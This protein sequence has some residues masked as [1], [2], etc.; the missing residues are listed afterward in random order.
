LAIDNEWVTPAMRI[1]VGSLAGMLLV[2]AGP[3]FRRRGYALYGQILAGGGVAMLYLC[4][5]AAFNYYAL[6]GANAAFALMVLITGGAAAMAD[7]EQSQGLA[8]MAVG[9]GFFTPF[10]VNSGRDAQ[11][12]L[13]GYDA[14]LVA[15]TMVLAR[16]RNWPALNAVSFVLTVAT[17]AAWAA[18]YYRPDR[19]L[20]TYLFL[21]AFVAMFIYIRHESRRW[22]TAAATAVAY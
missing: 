1:V 9:G 5:Y 18:E 8:L 6:I 16:R 14:V 21:T 11:V 22:G 19:W 3:V 10:L 4:V 15:A 7:R 13:F 20:T 17:L 12:A 2:A